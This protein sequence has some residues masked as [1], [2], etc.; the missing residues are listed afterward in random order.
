VVVK[1]LAEALLNNAR[2]VARFEREAE[3]LGAVRHAN[4]VSMLG[5]GRDAGRAWLVMEYVP[6]ML[7]SDLIALRGRMGLRE[8][9]PIAAQILN[10][11]GHAHA[12]ELM[13]RDIKPSNVM[14]CQR[15]GRD[16]FVKVLDFGLAK[17]L[18]DE[19]QI[20]TD[21]VMGTVGYVAPEALCGKPSD[22][23]VDI[24][25]VGVLFYEM[26]CGEL[27]F[28]GETNAAIF[29]KTVHEAAPDLE[30]RLP[31]CHGIP[32]PI[33]ELVHACL[34]KKP[35][36]RPPDANALL[37]RL[38]DAVPASYFRLPPATRTVAM[39]DAV[40]N[41]GMIHLVETSRRASSSASYVAG[42][43]AV[44]GAVTAIASAL[45]LTFF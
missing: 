7:L 22:L 29:Y 33:I 11:I 16:N 12:H 37:E 44:V 4:I 1:F 24:Y 27:P 36:D 18:H 23:R 9:V 10:G 6:G 17:R 3:R 43:F 19:C 34:Q 35:E 31:E 8:F 38:V 2:A 21:H 39:P 5:H 42:A 25:A 14:L 41:T 32:R 30:T 15:K 28:K 45:A 13:I 26:L 40:G 20:T